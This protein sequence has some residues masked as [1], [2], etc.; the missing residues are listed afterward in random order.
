M[1]YVQLSYMGI[2]AVCVQGDTLTDPYRAG[3]PVRRVL[4]TPANMGA[5]MI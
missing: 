3:Y 4:R 2:D 1:C 5:L